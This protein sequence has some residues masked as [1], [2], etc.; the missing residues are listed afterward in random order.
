VRES[1]RVCVFVCV[2]VCV[3]ECVCECVCVCVLPFPG[4]DIPNVA[5]SLGGDSMSLGKMITNGPS[6]TSLGL[7]FRQEDVYHRCIIE[8]RAPPLLCTYVCVCECACVYIYIYIYL[9]I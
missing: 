3:W 9:L 5:H 8:V 4:A 1:E 7:P 6:I 2:C